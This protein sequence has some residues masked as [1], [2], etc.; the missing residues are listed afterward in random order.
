[1]ADTIACRA[2]V[3]DDC[4]DGKPL[5][6]SYED[7]DDY[8]DDGTFDGKSVVC[9]ACYVALM[10]YTRSGRAENHELPRAIEHL[11]S[12]IAWL[13]NHDDPAA[14]VAE[15]EAAMATVQPGC[16]FYN[17]AAANKRLAEAE[18]K[19]RADGT[20]EGSNDGEGE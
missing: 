20:T 4:C 16:P 10:P 5:S 18:V 8:H 1:M 7:V 3:H 19:R 17:S 2:K 12:Q 13:R 6:V 14:L 9:N 11:R 15:A